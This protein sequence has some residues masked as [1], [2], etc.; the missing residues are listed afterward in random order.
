MVMRDWTPANEGAGFELSPILKP[1]AR[2][3][4]RLLV[5]TGLDNSKGTG[6]PHA[7]ASAKFL[8]GVPTISKTDGPEILAGTSIDQILAKEWGQYT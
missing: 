4:N 7:S 8:S 6:G 1:L 3:Q 5:V 2:F